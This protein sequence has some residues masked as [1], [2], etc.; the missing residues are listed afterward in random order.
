M[1]LPIPSKSVSNV[2]VESNGNA[3]KLSTT[4][5]PSSSVSEL[6]P[7]PSLSVSIVSDRSNGNA[8]SELM[9]PSLSESQFPSKSAS[10]PPMTLLTQLPSSS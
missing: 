5:S 3:S 8:S 2:S 10:T 7:I 9:T 1:L 4:P 6:F